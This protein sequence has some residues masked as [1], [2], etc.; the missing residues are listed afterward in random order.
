MLY[1]LLLCLVAQEIG[2]MKLDIEFLDFLGVGLFSVLGF[3]Y[4]NWVFLTFSVHFIDAI[5]LF[6]SFTFYLFG[7]ILISILY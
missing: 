5:G 6:I 7:A 1:P 4:D 2:E 3:C